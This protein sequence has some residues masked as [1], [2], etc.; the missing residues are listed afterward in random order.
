MKYSIKRKRRFSGNG[1]KLIAYLAML[2]GHLIGSLFSW[3]QANSTLYSFIILV[4][5]ILIALFSSL[6]F[7]HPL[8][9]ALDVKILQ[10]E[11]TTTSLK[12]LDSTSL[13]PELNSEY[14]GQ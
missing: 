13:N 5:A 11:V 2:I 8:M 14:H 6:L 1:L 7:G 3:P 4:T 9:Q 12:A 10:N